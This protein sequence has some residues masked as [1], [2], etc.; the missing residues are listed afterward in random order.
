MLFLYILLSFAIGYLF[1]CLSPAYAIGR[2][3]GYDV[4]KDGSGNV[5]ASNAFILAG[6]NAFFLTAILDILKAFAACRLARVL[7][8]TLPVA[9]QLAG[10]GAILGHMYPAPLGF[11]GGRGLSCLGGVILSWSWKWFLLLLAAAVVL[12]FTVRYVCVVAPTMSVAFPACYFWQTGALAGALVL[13]LAAVPIFVKHWEN[14]VRI[15]EGTELRVD[16]I[17]DKEG[18]LKR[19]GNW[20]E[21]TVEQLERRSGKPAR[22]PEE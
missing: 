7:F 8:P 15:R 17:W 14:F 9:E 20:N 5:G 21:T 16:F 13:L 22:P 11:R 6:K 19:T 18:E 10:V 4:R 3:R 12:A 2:S 1:G